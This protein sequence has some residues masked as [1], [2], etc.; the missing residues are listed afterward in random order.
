MYQKHA[1][2]GTGCA[3]AA[4]RTN[5][6]QGIFF[7]NTYK[8]QYKQIHT[9]HPYPAMYWENG[10]LPP[11][12][13]LLNVLS[14][15]RYQKPHGFISTDTAFKTLLFCRKQKDQEDS[16][17][18]PY[19]PLPQSGRN[20]HQRLLHCNLCF[21]AMHLYFRQPNINGVPLQPKSKQMKTLSFMERAGTA[22]G[23]GTA[24]GQPSPA[25]PFSVVQMSQDTVKRAF[26]LCD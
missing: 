13:L 25:Q 3:L 22:L 2:Y 11:N 17:D 4:Q 9:A 15:Y 1:H 26:G 12:L 6:D 10:A 16:L 21:E 14:Q 8:P 24:L 7:L 20:C 5:S 18:S 19:C 23:T